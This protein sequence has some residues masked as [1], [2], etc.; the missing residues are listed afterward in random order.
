[1]SEH[2]LRELLAE[3]ERALGRQWIEIADWLREQNGLEA[4]EERIRAGD[5]EGVLVEV[6]AAA[7]RFAAEAHA[8]FIRAGQAGS[9]WLD[10]QLE[11]RLVRFDVTNERAVRA[12]QR[13]ELALVRGLTQETRE[14]IRA[15]IIDGQ[16]NGQNPRTIARDIRDS[17]T[18]TPTQ[19][20]HVLNY[21]RELQTGRWANAL[22][23]EL[24]DG[25]ADRTLERLQRDGGALTEQQI[26]RLVERYRQ[27]YIT[28]RAEAIART[29]SA[30]NVH[31]GLDEAFRQAIERG[32]IEA[33]M[34][35]REWIHARRGRD[36][37]PDHIAMDGVRV[38]WGEPFVLPDGSRMMY[39][40]DPAGGPEN[41]VHCRCTVATTLE[42]I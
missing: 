30:R 36:S 35:V 24:R 12:A 21:R 16:R 10:D 34:V 1:M 4:I 29:E 32:D 2:D 22:E 19:A 17:I 14:T 26:E 41:T 3:V 7:R 28:Y 15:V 25:R 38:K 9:R 5:F 39:P 6:E 37:R 8:Q 23:R 31:A 20:R 11:D 33:G 13:N 40:G 18:L 27:N 42:G